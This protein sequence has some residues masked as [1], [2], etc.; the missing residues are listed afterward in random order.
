MRYAF[1]FLSI[2]AMWVGLLAIAASGQVDTTI[3]FLVA[4]F[5]TLA[6]FV[7]GFRRSKR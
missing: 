5:M 4:T 6:L 3:L 1:V 2:V 7:I